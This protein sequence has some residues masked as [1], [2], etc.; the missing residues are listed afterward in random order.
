VFSSQWVYADQD[1]IRFFRDAE[2]SLTWVDGYSLIGERS[3]KV[4]V[5]LLEW[6]GS[7][8]GLAAG[9]TR[10]EAVLQATFELFERHAALSIVVGERPVPVLEV[11]GVETDRI[12]RMRSFLRRHGIETLFFD[13]SLHG[14]LPCVGLLARN[15]SVPADHMEH[16]LL[17]F[18]A[19]F[20][21]EERMTRCLIECMQGRT[22]DP[23]T[24]TVAVRAAYDRP[25]VSNPD[26]Y[27]PLFSYGIPTKPV[28]FIDTST[29]I[30]ADRQFTAAAPADIT[31]EIAAIRAICQALSSDWVAVDIGH[32]GVGF[33]VVRVVIPRLLTRISCITPEGAEKRRVILPRI[34]G[35]ANGQATAERT[36]YGTT[37]LYADV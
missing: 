13:A 24:A 29:R 31:E 30:A 2:L 36:T 6:V 4:P 37:G 16:D 22:A 28:S 21:L 14:L 35:T 5:R 32:P 7:S 34:M 20:D 17:F 23:T 15:T 18:G 19:S 10:A 3:I 12:R 8:N 26:N 11:T 27:T 33:P 1:S 9:N 25:V